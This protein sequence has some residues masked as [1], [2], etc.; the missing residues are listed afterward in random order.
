M[1]VQFG[2]DPI[3]QFV[4]RDEALP[5]YVPMGLLRLR[6]QVGGVSKALIQQRD[7]FFAAVGRQ[8]D[9]RSTLLQSCLVVRIIRILAFSTGNPTPVFTRCL[10]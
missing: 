1:H 8:V 10:L 9:L 5:F 7:Q 6:S 3:E 2:R 4:R